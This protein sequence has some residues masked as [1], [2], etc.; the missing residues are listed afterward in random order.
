MYLAGW[1]MLAVATML[2][3]GFGWAQLQMNSTPT[4]WIAGLPVVAL[5]ALFLYVSALLGQRLGANE[6]RVLVEA[7][8][9][10][11]GE[12]VSGVMTE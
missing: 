1:G 5:V 10:A 12:D 9:D 6:A 8:H 11:I 2:V 7:A 4:V 3:V